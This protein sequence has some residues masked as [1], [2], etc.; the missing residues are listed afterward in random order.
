MKPK[1][2][3]K[4]NTSPSSWIVLSSPFGGSHSLGLDYIHKC[5][6]VL[7]YLKKKIILNLKE[8]KGRGGEEREKGGEKVEEGEKQPD[9]DDLG[10][11]LNFSL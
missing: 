10:K 2:K 8:G 1:K 3:K 11:L 9:S 7:M 6:K 4:K 5:G